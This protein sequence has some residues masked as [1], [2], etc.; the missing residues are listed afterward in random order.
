MYVLLLLLLLLVV[1][2]GVVVG[3][4]G[5]FVL[6]DI[7]CVLVSTGSFG[8]FFICAA[9]IKWCYVTFKFC[10]STNVLAGCF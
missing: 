6:Q 10:F 1:V 3:K 8:M 5:K 9:G 7:V 4:F 2:V